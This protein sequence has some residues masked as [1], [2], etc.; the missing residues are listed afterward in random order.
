ME[1]EFPEESEGI[2]VI[3]SHYPGQGTGQTQP[4]AEGHLPGPRGADH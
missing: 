3:T 2:I 4:H 1:F